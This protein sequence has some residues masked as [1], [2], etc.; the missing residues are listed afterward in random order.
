MNP[1]IDLTKWQNSFIILHTSKMITNCLIQCPV[2]MIY[3]VN[4]Q[5]R[6]RVC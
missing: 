5:Q 1:D 2:D 6:S 4:K 3:S